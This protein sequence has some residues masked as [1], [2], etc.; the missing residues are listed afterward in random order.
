[1]ARHYSCFRY[2]RPLYA[3][4]RLFPQT[5]TVDPSFLAI[6]NFSNCR[7]FRVLSY[8]LRTIRFPVIFVFWF[9]HR[10]RIF[11][12]AEATASEKFAQASRKGYGNQ[13]KD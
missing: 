4:E 5:R 3:F 10:Y 2:A 6:S 9:F 7:M 13:I 11:T 1:M 12:L 8:N